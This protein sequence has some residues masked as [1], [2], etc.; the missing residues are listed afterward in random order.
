MAQRTR[1]RIEK[2]QDLINGLFFDKVFSLMLR[3]HD[4]KIRLKAFEIMCNMIHQN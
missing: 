2:S 1:D 4:E 3:T